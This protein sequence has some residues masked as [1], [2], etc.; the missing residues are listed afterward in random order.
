[1]LRMLRMLRM[2]LLRMYNAFIKFLFRQLSMCGCLKQTVQNF[3]KHFFSKY[4]KR[5]KTRSFHFCH[6]KPSSFIFCHRYP[7]I[8]KHYSHNIKRR[9][10]CTRKGLTLDLKTV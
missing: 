1:M 4:C 10:I 2:H 6:Q 9:Q 3:L 7:K 5:L 8:S